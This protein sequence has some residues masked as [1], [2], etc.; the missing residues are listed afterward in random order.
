M[1]TL[2]IGRSDSYL[3]SLSE[4]E[5]LVV[6]SLLE[7][8]SLP[9]REVREQCPCFGPKHGQRGKQ[10]SEHLLSELRQELRTQRVLRNIET[11]DQMVQAVRTKL[12]GRTDQE[13]L[14]TVLML[15]GQ[16]V[17]EASLANGD[18]IAQDQR[19]KA[20]KLLLKKKELQLL[21][22]RIE[23]L[24]REAAKADQAKTVTTDPALSAEEKQARYRQIFGLG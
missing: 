16:E 13:T 4:E 12:G 17:I 5:R 1:V 9:L 3:A 11:A 22:R 19:T 20:A 7:D 18:P 6:Q 14:D 8:Y 23:H 24:E 10:P 15:V 2:D 21:E